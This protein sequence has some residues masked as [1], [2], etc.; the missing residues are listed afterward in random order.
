MIYAALLDMLDRFVFVKVLTLPQ[1]EA[2]K[3]D[4]VCVEVIAIAALR[5]RYA[6]VVCVM[7]ALA[8]WS[9]AGAFLFERSAGFMR[10]VLSLGIYAAPVAGLAFLF[11]YQDIME[12][13]ER[14]KEQCDTRL[15]VIAMRGGA[16]A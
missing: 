6:P 10:A 7:A 15:R 8:A 1:C 2:L 12:A 3:K 9:V 14:C 11:R 16:S 13:H 4:G 5:L